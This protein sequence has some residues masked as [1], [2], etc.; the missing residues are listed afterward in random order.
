MRCA[1]ASDG[2][3]ATASVSARRAS[4][5]CPAER[6]TVASCTDVIGFDG[7]ARGARG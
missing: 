3:C 7:S 5:V 6:C 4:P 2:F 1:V